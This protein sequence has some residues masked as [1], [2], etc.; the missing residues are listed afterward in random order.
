MAYRQGETMRYRLTQKGGVPVDRGACGAYRAHHSVTVA[1]FQPP[2]RA[3]ENHEDTRLVYSLL[4]S[5]PAPAHKKVCAVK[6]GVYTKYIH[7][8]TAK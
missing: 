3:L 8:S 2:T 4:L 6:M 5:G 7:H 1:S